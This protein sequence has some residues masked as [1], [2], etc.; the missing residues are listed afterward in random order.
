MSAAPGD[1]RLRGF[2]DQLAV[3][4]ARGVLRDLTDGTGLARGDLIL[5]PRH[6]GP[7]PSSNARPAA[8]PTVLDA[9]GEVGS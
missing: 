8:G 2:L 9:L 7:L 3:A 6:A 4:V 5:P 1:P